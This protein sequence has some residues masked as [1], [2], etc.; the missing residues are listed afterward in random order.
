MDSDIK[1][2]VE[3]WRERCTEEDLADELSRLR[4]AAEQG[5]EGGLIDAFYQH[6]VFG[7]AGLRGVIGVGTNRMNVHTVAQATQGLA[8]Y[9]NAHYESPTVAIARD[10]RNK[11]EEFV[12]VAASVLAANGVKALLYPRIEPVPALSFAVRDLHASAGICMTASHNPAPYNGYKVYGDDGC[13]I[14]SQAAADI[15]AAINAT[16]VFDGPKTMDFD[17]AVEAGLIEW[18]GEDTLDRFVDAVLTQSVPGVMTPEVS[19]RFKVVYTPLNGTGIELARRV[20][21]RI[22][23]RNVVVVPEQAQPDG[24]FPT[25]PYPNPEIREALELGIRLCE[26]EKPD[27]LLANDPDADR[28]GIAVPHDGDYVLLTGNEVGILL[29]DWL[30]RVKRE[31]GEDL[32]DRVVVSTIVSSVMPDALAEHYGFEMRRVLTGF[33]YIGDQ[34]S[35]LTRAGQEGRFLFGYEESYGYLAGCHVRDKDGIVADML[36]CEMAAWYAARGRDLAQAMDDLYRQFGYYLNKTIS[37]AFPGAE[38][39]EQMRAIMDGLHAGKIPTELAGLAV[40]G[41]TDYADGATMPVVPG[42]GELAKADEAAGRQ[43]LPGANVVELRLDGG[44][45]VIVRP[46][47]TEPKVKLYVFAKGATRAEAEALRDRLGEAAR[48]LLA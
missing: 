21:D 1:S 12:R 20:L 19:E 11:G 8:Q 41:V 23:V 39:H 35:M 31:A 27:L 32:G 42:T 3:L 44:N 36:I 37:V 16:D 38:G 29:I 10:S 2:A 9:L 4:Q 6:L 17:E 7:T 24:D 43:T 22:G 46:S 13:Q 45:R 26:T 30:C 15:Q 5:D 14:T 40:Q 28:V 34:I 33:K 25:C 18:I 48:G 47:G